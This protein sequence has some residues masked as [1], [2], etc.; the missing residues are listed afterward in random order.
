MSKHA[1]TDIAVLRCLSRRFGNVWTSEPIVAERAGIPLLGSV[2]PVPEA[3]R[4]AARP[5]GG[6][7][8]SWR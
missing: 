3:D 6:A 2:S 4:S 8:L 5:P 7:C 1:Q